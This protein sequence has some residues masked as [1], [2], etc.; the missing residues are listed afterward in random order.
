MGAAGLVGTSAARAS[1]L[2]RALVCLGLAG[3]VGQLSCGV[4]KRSSSGGGGSA[5]RAGG[6][7]GTAGAAAGAPG[8]GGSHD[9]GRAAQGGSSTAGAPAGAAGVGG[10]GAAG[11]SGGQPSISEAGGGGEDPGGSPCVE[12]VPCTC[13]ELIG[14]TRCADDGDVER[15]VCSCP[16]AESCAPPSGECFE[17]CG[18]VP[19]G[20]WV[21]EE[22]CFPG[23][24]LGDACPG[25]VLDG[26][27]LAADLKLRILENEPLD[28]IGSAVWEIRSRVPTSCLGIET[29]NRCEAATFYPEPLLGGMT[30]GVPCKANACGFC[31]CVGELAGGAFRGNAP[32]TPQSS[33]LELGSVHY[34]YCVQGDTLW[35]GGTDQFAYPKVSYRFRRSSCVGTPVPCEARTDEACAVGSGCALGLCLP[36]SGA[37][38]DDCTGYPRDSCEAVAQCRWQVSSCVGNAPSSCEFS[39][40]DETPGC[41]WG[42]PVER[43]GGEP[44]SCFDR[45]PS[46]CTTAGCS[47]RNCTF[48]GLNDRVSCAM[49]G[50]NA[51]AR[52]SGCSLQN[53]SCTGTT[54]CAEQTDSEVCSAFEC[55]FDEIPFCGGSPT[56]VCADLT[57][58]TCAREPGCRIEW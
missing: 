7:S 37:S 12:G 27:P 24:E 46:A 57:V 56:A 36:R 9:G 44:T 42:A 35:L 15:A 52:A 21:A 17:P 1:R 23:A 11:G 41:G 38:A 14:T 4:S 2:V 3:A 20:V 19:Y 43:C 49:V 34:P 10:P 28:A 32:W 8:K 39:N 29:V 31:D 48:D 16:P 54:T 18:G 55:G 30:V 25:A 40:C 50:A 45:D 51:C 22:A 58:A 47:M 6:A 13:A 5:G 26:S 33:T 53:G